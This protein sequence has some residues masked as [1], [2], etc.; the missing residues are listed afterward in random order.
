M[1]ISWMKKGEASAQL[2]KQ[3]EAEAEKAKSE[4]GKMFRFWLKDKESAQIT[5]VDGAL[6]A[7]GFLL[8]P[9]FWEHNLNLNGTWN[10]YYVCPDKSDPQGGHKCPICE[11]GD[12]PSLISLFTIIDHRTFPGK[13]D[14]KYVNTRKLLAVKPITFELLNKA[15]LKRGGLAG[16]TFEVSR[17]GDKA[18]SVGSVFDF[19]KKEEDLDV[20]RQKY[21][22]TV[23]DDKGNEVVKTNFEPAD[24]EQ[25]IVYRTEEEL[26]NL[27]FGKPPS[28][29]GMG[30]STGGST[31]YSKDL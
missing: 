27:G 13:N 1:A 8:P 31:D 4:Q 25:E 30:G 10:N 18:A 28:M 19:E 9:R 15:A 2:A 21:T 14:K 29:S 17:I 26:R 5:F 6:S 11:G 12:K 3:Q 20:L 23:K 16:C 22:I 24:Y 7:D